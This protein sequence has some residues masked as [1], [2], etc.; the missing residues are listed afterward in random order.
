MST[1][2]NRSGYD[3]ESQLT[4][5]QQLCRQRSRVLYRDQALYLQVLRDELLDRTLQALFA[6]VSRVEPSRFS[7]LPAETRERFQASVTD[8]SK[9]CSALLT[10]EQ[11]MVLAQQLQDESVR[12]D[13][14]SRQEMVKVLGKQLQQTNQIGAEPSRPASEPKG[15]VHL[16]LDPPLQQP[17]L[18]G[19]Q[20]PSPASQ[21]QPSEMETEAEPSEDSLDE[22]VDDLDVLQSL[23]ELAGEALQS[24][25]AEDVGESRLTAPS[26]DALS[27][28]FLPAMPDAL[29]HWMQ[30][31]ELA[32][33]RRLRNLSHAINVEMLRS[34][35]ANALLP[36]TLLEAVLRGQVETQS[37]ASNVVRLR[38]PM[39]IGEFEQGMDVLCLLLRSSEFEFDSPRLRR[40]RHRLHEHQAALLKM[41]Q[42]QRHWQ[43]RVL[44]REAL[45]HWQSPSD[46][47][48]P[49]G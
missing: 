30:A 37:S 17:E 12:Q 41:V 13:E 21:D 48:P 27:T 36:I 39:P 10:V 9:R 20:R 29:L 4:Q 45:K 32:L 46:Q 1:T 33:A 15:S 5:L 23:F 44:D 8:L 7:A 34:G 19:L 14:R 25:S 18:F 26:S 49:G 38:L 42:Q 22:R 40:V 16:S 28:D 43:R 35:L 11:L 3:P 6:L 31:M 24:Q 2:D 47:T